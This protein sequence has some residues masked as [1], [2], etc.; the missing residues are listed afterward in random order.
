MVK[1]SIWKN[2]ALLAAS[3]LV[4]LALAELSLRFIPG[5]LPEETALRLHWNA[6]G[7]MPSAAIGDSVLGF[8]YPPEYSGSVDRGDTRFSYTTDADGFRNLAAVDRPADIVVVGDSHVFGWGVA[9]DEVWVHLL[10]QRLP[11]RAVKNLGLIGAAP[12]QYARVLE[13]YGLGR[14]PDHP[15]HI[16]YMLFPGNDG[17]DQR[18][19]DDWQ[20]AGSPGNLDEWRFRRSGG[21]GVLERSA[22][23]QLVRAALRGRALRGRTVEFADGSRVRIALRA[24][25]GSERALAE[26]SPTRASVLESIARARELADSIGARFTLLLMPTKAEV[27]AGPGDEVPDL[28]SAVEPELVEAGYE[29][30]DVT[31]SLK[32]A[33]TEALFFEVDGHLNARGNDVVADAVAR[34]LAESS[35]PEPTG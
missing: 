20:A 13:R 8:R 21:P 11:D 5:L 23:L 3:G 27:Y 34:F 7:D 9:D 28:I 2:V 1:K 32:R 24:Y 18:V 17:S 12:E 31:E 29:V 6:I 14:A 4:T 30:L 33:S 22:L 26:G 15:R 19:F 35:E 16:L 10:D 25:A